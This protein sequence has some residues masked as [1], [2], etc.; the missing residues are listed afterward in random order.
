MIL[1]QIWS[2]LRAAKVPVKNFR[3]MLGDHGY[4]VMEPYILYK[5]CRIARFETRGDVVWLRTHAKTRGYAHLYRVRDLKVAL[6]KL[7][8][9][10]RNFSH[11]AEQP[12]SKV[13][14]IRVDAR[15]KRN[16]PQRKKMAYN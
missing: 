11:A 14:A 4:A 13:R 16:Q 5:D 9:S 8:E 7:R 6:H 1:R 3:R 10:Y 2:N 15:A 12:G